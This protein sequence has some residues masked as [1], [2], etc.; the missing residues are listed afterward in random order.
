MILG[1]FAFLHGCDEVECCIE[2]VQLRVL[3][4]DLTLDDFVV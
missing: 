4:Q 1:S 2:V 3:G